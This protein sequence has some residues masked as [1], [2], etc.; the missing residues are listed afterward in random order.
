MSNELER[1]RADLEVLRKFTED[2]IEWDL[3]ELIDVIETRVRKLEAGADPWREAKRLVEKYRGSEFE[4]GKI[5]AYC[6][7]LTAEN[8]D[9]K[10]KYDLANSTTRIATDRLNEVKAENARLEKRVAEL[11]KEPEHTPAVLKRAD[12]IA[13]G[14]V[15][16]AG[17]WIRTVTEVGGDHPN[18]RII[19]CDGWM[20]WFG[21]H[22][23][24]A[25]LH[26]PLVEAKTV[27]AKG[28]DK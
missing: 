25:V 14:D 10:A 6:D 12:E 24:I 28:G 9:I 21:N 23:L 8:A 26:K 19:R 13:V 11:E 27:L 20:A 2:G 18:R 17:V 22:D 5:V 16:I 3:A 15:I 4:T 7:H 1:L